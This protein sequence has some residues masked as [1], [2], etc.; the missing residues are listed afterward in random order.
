VA[1]AHL[2]VGHQ[3]GPAVDVQTD[4]VAGEVDHQD[5]DMG[6]LPDVAHGGH[7][8]VAA[9][10]RVAERL[11]VQD[12]QDPGRTGPERAVARAV[13]VRRG[14]EEHLLRRRELPHPGV[15]MVQHLVGVE[16]LG[17]LRRPPGALEFVLARA[18]GA[19]RLAVLA[20]AAREAA[21]ATGFAGSVVHGAV[22]SPGTG[23]RSR[24]VPPRNQPRARACRELP[25][26]A[27]GRVRSGKDDGRE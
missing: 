10:L 14:H 11:G 26:P 19:R 25:I 7:H 23:L 6:V 22:T 18:A 5:A 4:P 21:G 9:V 16:P 3:S 27:R 20:G 8:T 24:T 13:R 2:R 17:A 1:R 15:E 12:V